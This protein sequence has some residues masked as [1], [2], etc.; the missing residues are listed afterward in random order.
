MANR[1]NLDFSI[2]SSEDR[3]LFINAY[4][5]PSLQGVEDNIYVS[6][7]NTSKTPFPFPHTPTNTEL[8]TMA[9]YVLYGK[10]TPSEGFNVKADGSKSVVDEG[11]VQIEVRNSPWQ[12]KTP[13]SLD[14]MVEAAS[15]TGNPIE[16][17]YSLSGN[18]QG[19]RPRW[20]PTR[21]QK[22]TF[23]RKATRESLTQRGDLRLLEEFE[24]LWRRIDETEYTV[25]LYSLRTGRRK[26]PIRDELTAR[27]N[28]DQVRKCE[29]H[30]EKLNMYTWGKLRKYLVELRQQQYIFRDGYLPTIG[31]PR[32]SSYAPVNTYIRSFDEILPAGLFNKDNVFS[33]HIFMYVITDDHFQS[34][35]QALLHNYI[36]KQQ[37][38]Y[39][40]PPQGSFDFC[41]LDHVASLI[42]V[43]NDLAPGEE[44]A[45]EHR[46]ELT[47]LLDTLDYYIST[48]KL[49]LM[50]RDIVMLKSLGRTNE[51]IANYVNKEYDKTYSPNY[52]ST[53][54]RAKCCGGI[55][56]AAQQHWEILQSL[57]K[58]KDAFKRCTA[59][60]KLLLRS[61]NNFVR[62]SRAKD[63]LAGR[64]KACD[65]IARSKNKNGK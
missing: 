16:T 62:K 65:K 37:H 50:H 29:Q 23:S 36:E 12:K 17:Q 64:C 4:L 22:T 52:I 56:E 57:I 25:T 61:P 28:D 15:E 14:A 10:T 26:L 11:Y 27:L 41:N 33:D 9:D 35:F 19:Q 53:I 48:S 21:I 43:K 46:E 31:R 60:S 8:E 32:Q 44:V 49:E 63:G 42:Y 1:L 59:C 45:I 55:V 5:D 54:F 39:E 18:L 38:T 34:N 40:Q 24:D 3:Q 30:S 2:Y 58:G 6:K 47:M 13:D 51:T 7:Y 20:G